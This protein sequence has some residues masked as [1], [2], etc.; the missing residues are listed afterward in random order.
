MKNYLLPKKGIGFLVPILLFLLFPVPSTARALALESFKKEIFCSREVTA[1]EVLET[2]TFQIEICV[3]A[4]NVE[5]GEE[6]KAEKSSTVVPYY[7]KAGEIALTVYQDLD[8]RFWISPVERRRIKDSGGNWEQR[9]N[10]AFRVFWEFSLPEGDFWQASF[11]VQ[12][13]S[14]FLGGNEIPLDGEE[15]GVYRK[16]RRVLEFSPVRLNVPLAFSL[17]NLHL[18]LFLGEKLPKKVEGKDLEVAMLGRLPNW[19]G[20]GETG[21]LTAFWREEDETFI[22]ST[23]QLLEI[24]PKGCR[25]YLFT[26]SYSPSE[27]G[28]YGIGM[29]VTKQQAF[30]MLIVDIVQGSL[31]LRAVAEREASCLPLF[32]LEREGLFL[33]S[34]GKKEKEGEKTVFRAAFTGLPY[35]KYRVSQ[36]GLS[37]EKVEEEYWI[38]THPENDTLALSRNSSEIWLELSAREEKRE[39]FQTTAV[40]E[41]F[42]VAPFGEGH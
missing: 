3:W 19:Y 16:N 37:Y 21:T 12:A 20:K 4:E 6:G 23:E 15:S 5:K 8:P 30:S 33:Y 10:G 17:T 11:T 31:T 25:R 26:V 22:G 39:F 41:T 24:K 34:T 29:A 13:Q 2:R 14:D 40:G 9:E 18:E 32:L 28:E 36:I 27:K 1:Q 35:G 38:G 42:R 7:E